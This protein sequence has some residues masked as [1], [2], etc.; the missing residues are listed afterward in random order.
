MSQ[1]SWSNYWK[2]REGAS[3]GALT[4]VESDQELQAFWADA[5]KDGAQDQPLLDL[6]CGAGTVLKQA[7]SLGYRDLTGLDY[8]AEAIAVLKTDM[9]G[10]KTVTAS[11]AE[12]GLATGEYATIVSQ[13]GLEYAGAEA[14]FTEAARLCAPGGEIIT[15]MHMA[16]GGIEA[17]VKNHAAHCQSIFESTY[18]PSARAFFEAAYANDTKAGEIAA[19]AMTQARDRLTKIIVPD[20]HSLAAHL[21]AGTTELWNKRAN[22]ALKDVLGWLDG[23]QDEVE[24]YHTR[25]TAM[26]D[27][28]LDEAE[29]AT[30][31]GLLR[32]NG[33]R[34]DTARLS[35]SG[36]P[37]AWRLNAKRT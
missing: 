3:T 11:A 12:T 16:G 26:L 22:Y 15:I 17:E 7:A 21:M 27:A 8:S 10:I 19:K 18:I 35:L 29:V 28:A 9:P 36:Q 5:L 31:A 30:C 32:E 33:F 6:A 23:M 13:F 1:N 14:A 2:G 37:A 25:M 34:V 4:G 24:A 20:E